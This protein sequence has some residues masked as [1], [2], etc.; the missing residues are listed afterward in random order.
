MVMFQFEQTNINVL[1]FVV[2]IGIVSPILSVIASLF[3]FRFL[4]SAM[5]STVHLAKE[6]IVNVGL[7]NV[8]TSSSP[9][10]TSE[11]GKKSP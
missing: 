7:T 3:F 2:L 4:Y 10:K 11:A 9:K 1:I 8:P 6:P 5:S